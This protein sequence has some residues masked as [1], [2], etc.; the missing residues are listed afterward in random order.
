MGLL[1]RFLCATGA[2]PPQNRNNSLPNWYIYKFHFNS[3][4]ITWDHCGELNFSLTNQ[5]LTVNLK[6]LNERRPSMP[7]NGTLTKARIVKAVIEN[8]GYSQKKSFRDSRNN[9]RTHQALPGK[10]R[11]RPH[12]RLWKVLRQKKG[13]AERPE[14][15]DRRGHD[16]GAKKSGHLSEL[17][18]TKGKIERVK[19]F[20][21]KMTK[22]KS[23]TQYISQHIEN[24]R[25]WQGTTCT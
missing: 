18:E 21:A 14:P 8:N 17:Q 4:V 22:T 24:T 15:C 2:G 25:Y 6:S 11:R 19:G 5:S 10:R 3:F 9:A 1:T 20:R 13:G 23:D 7:K 16:D 12:L